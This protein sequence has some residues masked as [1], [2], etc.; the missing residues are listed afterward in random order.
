[1]HHVSRKSCRAIRTVLAAAL[2]GVSP[3]IFAF[4]APDAAPVAAPAGPDVT[5]VEVGPYKATA[6][7]ITA[8][9]SHAPPPLIADVQRSANSGRIQVVEWYARLLYE[10]AAK[11]DGLYERHPG[12]PG[13][14]DQRRRAV[15]GKAYI[16]DFIVQNYTPT[17]TEISSLYKVEGKKLCAEPARY[18]LARI[19]VVVGLHAS[20]VEKKEAAGRVEA[21]QKRLAAG[22]DFAKVADEVSDTPGRARGGSMGWTPAAD[23]EKSPE[24]APITA[25][26]TGEVS[27]PVETRHGTMIFRMVERQDARTL[28]LEQCRPR[29]EKDIKDSFK[30]EIARQRID[31]LA[32]RFGATINMD[33]VIAAIRAV[34]LAPDWQ[35]TWKPGSE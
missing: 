32:E 24:A 13:W 17:D 5:I 15:I 33:A 7:D 28:P 16:D 9:F 18:H 27:A 22:E 19:G 2:L 1:M 23:L 8:E 25:L 26:A 11:Q 4:A 35:A 12:L 10:A 14:A 34:P 3:S 31:D 6:A 30:R 29:L 20:D 21:V